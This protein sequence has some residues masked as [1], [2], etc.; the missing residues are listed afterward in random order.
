MPQSP[1]LLNLLAQF[2]QAEPLIEDDV[3]GQSAAG[4]TL[5]LLGENDAILELTIDKHIAH[6]DGDTS[7]HSHFQCKRCGRIIDIPL[8]KVDVEQNE[9]DFV[10]QETEV[11]YRGYCRECI[12]IMKETELKH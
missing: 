2:R 4:F 11:Y 5:R 6:Y 3:V 9:H 12:E 10:I 1:Q 7:P 8:Q